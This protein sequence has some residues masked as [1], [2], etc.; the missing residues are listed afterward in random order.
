[1]S[2]SAARAFFRGDQARIPRTVRPRA[3]ALGE[4]N[5]LLRRY[6]RLNDGERMS[7]GMRRRVLDETCR[8][9]VRE[10]ATLLAA[11]LSEEPDSTA[12]DA[13]VEGFHDWPAGSEPPDF[14]LL[15][16]LA[17]LYGR[18]PEAG[19][20]ETGAYARARRA[21][22]LF[23]RYYH[24]AA[25]FR[26]A[27]VSERWHDCFESDDRDLCRSGFRRARRRLGGLAALPADAG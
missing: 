1:L 3:A 20:R 9:R 22:D 24:H 13:W 4:R 27:T 21:T 19:R 7:D 11:W 17:E 14:E 5:S 12:V 6:A 16:E 15:T 26:R 2:H 25:P 8:I 18:A 23:A 10:C